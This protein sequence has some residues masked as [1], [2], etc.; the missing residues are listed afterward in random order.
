M[1]RTEQIRTACDAPAES[2]PPDQAPTWKHSW[3]RTGSRL[4]D[5]IKQ[6]FG[7]QQ[8]RLFVAEGTSDKKL[9]QIRRNG[10][11]SYCLDKLARTASPLVVF[12]HA[13]GESDAHICDAIANAER[14]PKIFVGVHGESGAPAMTQIQAACAAM[15]DRRKRLAQ[16]NRRAVPL[17]VIYYDA[18]SAPVWSAAPES[19]AG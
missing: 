14:L 17:D 6:G 15:Q 19:T 13:L 7:E 16:R 4:T 11:L 9:D 5:L 1:R 18:A 3:T 12:G 10:Y 2:D 8:Y